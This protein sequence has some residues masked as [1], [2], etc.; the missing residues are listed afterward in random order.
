MVRD[1]RLQIIW[2]VNMLIIS[3]EDTQPVLQ[4]GRV[5]RIIRVIWVTFCLDQS[6][7]TRT[8]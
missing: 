7:F 6:G 5:I 4:P 2:R 1:V 8:C 3:A